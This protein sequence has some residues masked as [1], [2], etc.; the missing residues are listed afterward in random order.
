MKSAAGRR[1][2]IAW[3]ENLELARRGEINPNYPQYVIDSAHAEAHRM[4]NAAAEKLRKAIR[5][6]ERA[7]KAALKAADAQRALVDG[8]VGECQICGRQIGTT[9]GVIAHHGY[10]RPGYGMQTASCLGA[11][12]HSYAESCDRLREVAAIVAAQSADADAFVVVLQTRPPQTLS[13]DRPT[14]RYIGKRRETIRETVERPA[15][16]VDAQ[17]PSWSLAARYSYANVLDEAR[18]NARRRAAALREMS[19]FLQRRLATWQLVR[20]VSTSLR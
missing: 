14:D 12:Y 16:F 17:A 15:D 18:R 20:S 9:V 6:A 19:T 10:E 13:Y 3:A 11:R 5:A 2:Q 4:Q 1:L 7:A 8:T